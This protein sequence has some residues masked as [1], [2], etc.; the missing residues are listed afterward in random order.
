MTDQPPTIPD[1]GPDFSVCGR[2][3]VELLG[4]HHLD[5]HIEQA[6]TLA[7][8]NP[9]VGIAVCF[10]HGEELLPEATGWV[11]RQRELLAAWRATHPDRTGV[12][13][14]RTRTIVRPGE[15]VKTLVFVIFHA[16]R[17]SARRT[18]P[19]EIDQ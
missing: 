13:K 2:P 10:I 19:V 4:Y 6:A 9:K 16:A 12:L 3:I 1:P 14:L 11:R 17:N 8:E 5:E 7:L 18:Q 15:N